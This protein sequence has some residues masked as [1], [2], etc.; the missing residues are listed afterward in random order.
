M[1]ITET[2]E[3]RLTGV[4]SGIKKG[5]KTAQDAL[6]LLKRMKETNAY[7]AEDFEKKYIAAMASRKVA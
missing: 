5:T 6:P 1:S 2:L 4:I 3:R 7:L